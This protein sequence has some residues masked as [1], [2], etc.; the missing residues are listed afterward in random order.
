MK[1]I[2]EEHTTQRADGEIFVEARSA[3]DMRPSIPAGVRIHVE[4]GVVTLTGPV[5]WPAERAE[6]ETAVRDI[7]GVRRVIN[8][9]TVSQPASAEGFEAPGESS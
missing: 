1:R 8:D 7:P 6:A 2:V 3:L 4:E 5:R 9:I